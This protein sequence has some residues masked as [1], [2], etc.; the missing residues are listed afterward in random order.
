MK[1]LSAAEFVDYLDAALPASRQAHLDG[2]SACRAQADSL[3]DAASDLRRL[4]Q[5]DAPEPSPLFWEHFSDRVR[6]AVYDINPNAAS[7]RWFGAPRVGWAGACAAIVLVTAAALWFTPRSSDVRT[8]PPAA[9]DQLRATSADLPLDL[10]NDEEWALVRDVA[11]DLQW[12]DAHEA[13]LGPKP[14]SAEGVA[15][16]L[17][18]AERQELARLIEEEIKHTGA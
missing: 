1:H 15:L 9:I 16:E 4:A 2:C 18:P 10:D 13:G 12:D 14:G 8:A 7:P 6:S 11:D 3:R 17:S 5:H